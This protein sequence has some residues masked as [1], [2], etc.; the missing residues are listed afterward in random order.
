MFQSV[1]LYVLVVINDDLKSSLK[2]R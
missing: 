1:T 2:K